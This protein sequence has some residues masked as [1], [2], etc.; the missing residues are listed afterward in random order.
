MRTEFNLLPDDYMAHPP[1]GVRLQ[2]NRYAVYGAAVLCC[3]E[4]FVFSTIQ[5]YRL[6]NEA[7]SLSEAMRSVQERAL[8]L[9]QRT[10]DLSFRRSK[11]QSLLEEFRNCAFAVEFLSDVYALLPESGKITSV[12]ADSRECVISGIFAVS[13]DLSEFLLALDKKFPGYAFAVSERRRI[14]GR[15]VLFK[16][17]VSRRQT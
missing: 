1:S 17:T 9:N 15:N 10:A 8:D 13:V 16:V 14:Y 5:F 3:A 7:Q 6:K 4:F 11:W 12:S 2:W